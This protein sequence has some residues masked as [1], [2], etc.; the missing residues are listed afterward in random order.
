[1]EEYQAFLGG[2]RIFSKA[3]EHLDEIWKEALKTN[4][5]QEKVEMEIPAMV[6]KAFS[7]EIGLKSMILKENGSFGRIHKLDELFNILEPKYK[8]MIKTF[9]IEAMKRIVG[10]EHYSEEKFLE[11][12]TKNGNAFVRWRYFFEKNNEADITFLDLLH[13]AIKVTANE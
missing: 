2:M 7:C 4:C 10:P 6:L 8:I 5:D 1:M 12:L 11:D 13:S 3:S 9:V